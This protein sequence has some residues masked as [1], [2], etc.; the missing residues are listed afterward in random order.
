VEKGPNACPV[1]SA[2]GLVVEVKA[3]YALRRCRFFHRL[4][5]RNALIYTEMLTTGVVLRGDRQ[6]LLDFDAF[7][8]KSCFVS[9]RVKWRL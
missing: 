8:G 7:D 9:P 5:T 2:L 1:R 6:R 4:L 3:G